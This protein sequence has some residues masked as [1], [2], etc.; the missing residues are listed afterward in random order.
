MRISRTTR[1]CTLHVKGYGTYQTGAAFG[2]KRLLHH[3]QQKSR[4]KAPRL[5]SLHLGVYPPS[6]ILQINR[7]FYH[8]TTASHVDEEITYSRVPLL[9]GSYPASSLLRTRPP[10]SR[11]R[12]ISRCLRLY[13]LPCSTD[14]AMGR[15]RFL[16]LHSMS[17]SPCYPYHPAGVTCR[18]SQIATGHA[19][20]A[21]RQRVRPPEL[22]FSR[23]PVGS[24]T[25]RPGDLL[26]LRTRALSIGFI[27]FVS[28]TDAIQAT[29]ILTFS[30]MGLTP[31]EHAYL[32]WTH[33]L[34]FSP[35]GVSTQ[36]LA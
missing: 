6:Q 21:R 10:P 17:L 12:P 11:L 20:F 31:T 25:L 32:S 36:Q 14:F 13:G 23:P 18:D 27:S 24:L 7:C 9:H 4:F 35:S 22:K 30:P 3:F 1:S 19:A 8:H 34:P 16:Q 33:S 28:S 26:T 5:F 15:G 29:G 2:T